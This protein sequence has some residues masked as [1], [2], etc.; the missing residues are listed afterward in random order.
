[1]LRSARSL[2]SSTR[3]QVML[4]E[5]EAELVALVEVVVDH[6]RQQVVGGRDG[7]E[8]A[9]EVEVE[10]LHRDDLAVAA[11][12]RAALDAERRAHRRLAHGD[13]RRLPMCFIAWP[14]PTVVVVL[15][16]PSGVGV[17]AV[18][19]TYFAFGR[20]AQ[21]VDRLQADLGEARAVRLEQVLADAH[22]RRRSRAAAWRSRRGR[23]P[24][25]MGR[26]SSL[27]HAPRSF[28]SIAAL[29]SRRARRPAADREPQ[30]RTRR[31][32]HDPGPFRGAERRA[33]SR[34]ASG[35]YSRGVP[36]R[37]RYVPYSRLTQPLV[38]DNGE[39]RP[40]S[41]DEALGRAAD[42]FRSHP[43]HAR[44]PGDRVLLVLEGDQR[45]ELH[46]PEA[47]SRRQSAP[48]T[49]TPATALD[50][51]PAWSVWRQ[52]SEPAA[53]PRRIAEIEDTDVIVMWGSNAR[54]A[55]PIFFHHVLAGRAQRR[56]AL[57]RRPAPQRRR[58]SSPIVWL[59]LDVGTDIALV[60]HDRPR[61]HPR[62]ARQH[63]AS[64][65]GRRRASTSTRRRSRSGRSS[66]A[67]EVTGVPAEAIRELAH[68]YASADRAQ[69]CW[70]LGITEHHN[71]VDNVLA[72]INLALLVRPRRPVGLRAQPVARPEQR[73]GRRRHGRPPEPAARLPGHRRRRGPGQVRAPWGATIPPR[74]G[75]HLTEMFEAMERGELRALYVIGENPAQSEA[76]VDHAIAAAARASTTSSCRTSSSPRPPSWP[77]SCCPGRRR[78]ARPRA[79]SP[80]P[81]GACSGPQGARPARRR[82]RRHRDPPR[83]RP[84]ASGTT[85]TYG[86]DARG[87]SGTSCARCR[88]CTPGMSYARLEELGGIQWPCYSRGPARAVVP[89][90][91][92]VGRRSRRAGP[93][94]AVQRRHRRPAGRPARRRVPAAATTGRRLD[95]YNTGVQSGG[96]RIARC[97]AARRS[98]SR[99][100]TPP[101]LGIDDGEIV[102]CRRGAARSRRRCASIPGC[103]RA[104]VH[105]LPLPRRGRRPTC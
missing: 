53:A 41:W 87:R 65:S 75:W 105:D 101:R 84:P 9:G 11:A 90:R 62:R 71:G 15:P 96:Y 63:D 8:V 35:E 13:H 58:R 60:E 95:S 74:N 102:R 61:D 97:A 17:I 66:A 79:R 77:T 19:T 81:S 99:R 92:A 36:R 37:H 42:G 33:D 14:R 72:L 45:D 83:R 50:T 103:G 47:R 5:V 82:P 43:R 3:R 56:Q 76:D 91:P 31:L 30:C 59:G 6:R 70:T 34:Q 18:T 22:L 26:T 7:V 48:T 64:S 94:G 68:A 44:R 100:R 2:T 93:A 10:Q 16:S 32:F 23:S 25:R 40:A 28:L 86:V 46:R 27:P 21:L 55:H 98:T 38:R 39:L 4:Y 24:G 49:S 89:P 69:M 67:R 88:R 20:S 57:R 29:A 51:L 54:D 12:G 80:T 52:S 1:M 104:G 73:A 85:G 78:G